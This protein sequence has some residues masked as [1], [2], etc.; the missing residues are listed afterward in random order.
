[1]K[2][3]VSS[4]LALLVVGALLLVTIT[5]RHG[6]RTVY[7]QGGCSPASLTGN[8]AFSHSGFTSKNVKGNPLPAAAVGVFS[9]DGS[10]NFLATYTDMSPGKPT[11]I[12]TQGTASGSYTV[13]SDC[14]GSG[15]F[16]SGN[17]AGLT[18]N[19]VIIGGGAEAFGIDTTPFLIATSDFKKQ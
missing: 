5:S 18:F 19:L 14:T 16:T 4:L 17:V 15:A 6:T 11:Y 2:R 10:G 3:I 7:A 9:F 8:Y 1:M 13:N 12:A